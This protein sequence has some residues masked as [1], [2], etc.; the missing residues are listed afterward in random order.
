MANQDKPHNPNRNPGQQGGQQQG[1]QHQGGQ[2]PGREGEV[3]RNRDRDTIQDED[4]GRR[5]SEG[6]LGNERTRKDES[7]RNRADQAPGRDRKNDAS[8]LPE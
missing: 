6:N 1:G 3:G 5:Q 7:V 2:K 8:R 4:L